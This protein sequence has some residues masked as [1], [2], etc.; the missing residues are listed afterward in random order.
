MHACTPDSRRDRHRAPGKQCA[1]S[2]T[3][4]SH[5]VAQGCGFDWHHVSGRARPGTRASRS[6]R[7][8]PSSSRASRAPGATLLYPQ[9]ETPQQ[10]T[11]NNWL[12]SDSTFASSVISSGRNVYCTNISSST[13]P[14]PCEDALGA[15]ALH[16]SKR[17]PAKLD[18][19]LSR[20]IGDVASRGLTYRKTK[21]S[22]RFRHRDARSH[23]TPQ[24]TPG[25]APTPFKC[26]CVCVCVCV[27][28]SL[29][30]SSS[31]TPSCSQ[32]VL[33]S[34][35]VSLS[36]KSIHAQK[37]DLLLKVWAFFY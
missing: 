17:R 19:F 10:E 14:E 2:H 33:V 36:H 12:R 21:A 23:A 20:A 28:E 27:C 32:L 4:R 1:S 26:V 34:Y 9:Q 15:P 31:F 25:D 30:C 13:K 29:S 3:L 6:Q 24:R 5:W 16:H 37:C 7:A 11:A 18:S 22:A 35:V 8:P